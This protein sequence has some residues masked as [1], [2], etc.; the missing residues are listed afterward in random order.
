M[1]FVIGNIEGIPAFALFLKHRRIG[2]LAFL[3]VFK[4]LAPCFP[5]ITKRFG[6]RIPVYLD[7]PRIFLVLDRVKCLLECVGIRF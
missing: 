4:K 6:M 3:E 5:Q 7:K 1:K 2:G